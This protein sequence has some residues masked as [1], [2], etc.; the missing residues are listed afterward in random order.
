MEPPKWCRPSAVVACFFTAND[1]CDSSATLAHS[2][3]LRPR[4]ERD[5]SGKIV[6]M[7]PFQKFD[8]PMPYGQ[9]DKPKPLYEGLRAFLGEHSAIY[10]HA[11]DV[12]DNIL[13]SRSGPVMDK[14]VMAYEKPLRREYVE[15]YECAGWA[16]S[17]LAS[18]CAEDGVRLV[19]VIIPPHL[20][21][22]PES[23]ESI[24]AAHAGLDG[25][26]PV[27]P[28]RVRNWAKR[29][30]ADLDVPCIDMTEALRRAIVQGRRVYFPR[31]GHLTAEG[32]KELANE[33]LPVLLQ[34]F[35][36]KFADRI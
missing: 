6:D 18:R 31:D 20:E 15:A 24:T 5:A 29:L 33:L 27:Q 16:I 9:S 21:V 12:K 32:H 10:R 8:P 17:R 11:R 1:I 2:I 26:R 35:E 13:A 7:L 36:P 28:D 4:F 30:C 23:W 34:C 14:R 22:S 25:A 19:V 3:S